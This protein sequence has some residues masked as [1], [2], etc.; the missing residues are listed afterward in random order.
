V[1]HTALQKDY[2][3]EFSFCLSSAVMEGYN[4]PLFTDEEIE[5]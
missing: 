2:G 4:Y 1:W 3:V 5:A